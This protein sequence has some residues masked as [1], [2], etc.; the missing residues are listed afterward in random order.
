MNDV[1]EDGNSQ[2]ASGDPMVG[3][4]TSTSSL[5]GLLNSIR[6]RVVVLNAKVVFSFWIAL[7]G[8]AQVNLVLGGPAGGPSGFLAIRIARPLLVV[9]RVVRRGGTY[10]EIVHGRPP[11]PICTETRVE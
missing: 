3:Q 2:D 7:G 8:L 11:G 6:R 1:T 9:V 10:P 5:T 4:A